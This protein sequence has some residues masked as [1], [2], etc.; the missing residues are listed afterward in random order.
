MKAK[1]F[2]IVFLLSFYNQTGFSQDWVVFNT[3]NSGLPNN[4]ITAV[5]I[6]SNGVKW[7]ATNNG[8]AKFDDFI[9]TTYNTSNSPIPNNVCYS[10]LAD[11]DTVWI[12]SV[13]GLVKFNG[14]LWTNY[15]YGYA[16]S[17]GFES[18]GNKWFG[19]YNA[20]LENFNGTSWTQYNSSNSLLTDYTSNVIAIDFDTTGNAWFATYS[21]GVLKYNGSTWSS[22]NMGN[23][24]IPGYQIS[25]ISID[26][27]QNKWV[28]TSNGI[29]KFDNTAWTLFNT[30][31]SNLPSN[32][33]TTIA[34]D[35]NNHKWV[36]TSGA[37]IADFDDATWITYNTSNSML[38]TNFINNITIDKYGNKWIGTA[39]GLVVFR[40]GG[41]ILSSSSTNASKNICL[42]NDNYPNPY[43]SQT[44]FSYTLNEQSNVTLNIY[45][46]Y[47]KK[48]DELINEK[49][50]TGYHCI[51]FDRSKLAA[52]IYFYELCTEHF[53]QTK[54]MIL[55]N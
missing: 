12:G 37:G 11:I 4:V 6:D 52:G 5:T 47:G 8:I 40:Q 54:K 34:F 20:W 30:S 35:A 18:N 48:I 1:C 33:V 53:R 43:S 36:G 3:S 9:W 25:D 19:L 39:V 27:A 41:I 44:V 32:V 2:I 38:P 13:L 24:G 10:I 21:D 28:S 42:L 16:I 14:T 15:P 49:Q 22:Y 46:L 45:D 51:K 23:S 7:I 29:E 26:A 31:N 55:T 17:M 50:V